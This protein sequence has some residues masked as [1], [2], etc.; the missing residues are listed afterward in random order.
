MDWNHKTS[1]FKIWIF[2][3]FCRWSSSRREMKNEGHK[4][5]WK[6]RS[7]TEL[8]DDK[9]NG[10]EEADRGRGFLIS[11]PPLLG[12]LKWDHP[13]FAL[14]CSP[15]VSDPEIKS[16]VIIREVGFELVCS[17]WIFLTQQLEAHFLGC[18]INGSPWSKTMHS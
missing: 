17:P 3:E 6:I 18:T 13:V 16:H 14:P 4:C 10:N 7:S 11:P 2:V 1:N 15:P 8:M 12:D 9:I 5:A